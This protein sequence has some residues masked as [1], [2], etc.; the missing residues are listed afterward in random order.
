MP[1]RPAVLIELEQL[2]ADGAV[3]QTAVLCWVASLGQSLTKAISD[4]SRQRDERAASIRLIYANPIS[5]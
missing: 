2:T 5:D 4:V 1:C 3:P